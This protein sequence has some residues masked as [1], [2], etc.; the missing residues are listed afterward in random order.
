MQEEH[1]HSNVTFLKPYHTEYDIFNPQDTPA[2][3]SNVMQALNMENNNQENNLANFIFAIFTFI[4]DY[5]QENHNA[6]KCLNSDSLLETTIFEQLSHNK[7]LIQP[8]Q[9]KNDI[10]M[11]TISAAIIENQP[12][13]KIIFESS[14]YFLYIPNN[15]HALLYE[16][17]I[18]EGYLGAL[19]FNKITST[20]SKKSNSLKDKYETSIIQDS[21]TKENV[22]FITY[23]LQDGIKTN[24]CDYQ[25]LRKEDYQEKKT[26]FIYCF[27]IKPTSQ[28]K[29]YGQKAL[30]AIENLHKNNISYIYL[31]SGNSDFQ[32]TSAERQSK[33]YKKC[34]FTEYK[35]QQKK[36][37]SQTSM[38]FSLYIKEVKK[39][40]PKTKIRES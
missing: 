5:I 19:C 32:K 10:P 24:G 22:G 27:G 20:L 39:S 30:Q 16:K 21:E 33:F 18:P 3:F 2:F 1:S 9:K 11:T 26:L 31:M 17:K 35:T 28:N 29:G 23:Q 12:W 40:E 25:K 13:K 14:R 8:I 34:G 38:F 15:M 7:E 6:G 4:T 36:R 37:S